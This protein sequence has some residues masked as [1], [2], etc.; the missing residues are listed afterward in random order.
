M[1]YTIKVI[2]DE[3][4]RAER[5]FKSDE[6]YCIFYSQYGTVT[7]EDV[8]FDISMN[9]TGRHLLSVLSSN[10]AAIREA[11]EL[12]GEELISVISDCVRAAEDDIVT[13]CSRDENFEEKVEY[14]K[15]G[16][17]RDKVAVL[18]VPENATPEMKAEF[19]KLE[20]LL[21]QAADKGIN[22]QDLLKKTLGGRA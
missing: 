22:P 16:K 2:N 1:G 6:A 10:V 4:G 14:V 20:Q 19:A 5:V 3:T 17:R 9:L 11:T 21:Q 13:A 12:R 7:N 15:K 18:G 8:K